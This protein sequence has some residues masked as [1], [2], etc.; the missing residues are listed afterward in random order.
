M[1]KRTKCSVCGKTIPEDKMNSIDIMGSMMGDL[2]GGNLNFMP[3][4]MQELPMKCNRCGTWI[5]N[6]CAVKTAQRANAGMIQ[7]SGCGGMFANP[8]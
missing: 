2:L 3:N 6:K 8:K 7:H 5:C 1:K 4:V